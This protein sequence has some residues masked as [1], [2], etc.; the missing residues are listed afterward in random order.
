MQKLVAAAPALAAQPELRG[1]AALRSIDCVAAR[2]WLDRRGAAAFPANVLSGFA[3]LEGAGGTWFHLN[4]LQAWRPGHAGA[5]TH[6]GG[7][8]VHLNGLQATPEC[9][10]GAGAHLRAR[11]GGTWV[12]THEA[13][14][15]AGLLCGPGR[16]RVAHCATSTHTVGHAAVRRRQ[17]VSAIHGCAAAW[18]RPQADTC[19]S[20]SWLSHKR[21]LLT[22]RCAEAGSRYW[23]WH[24]AGC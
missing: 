18:G 15:R 8:W 12:H 9:P 11:V 5:R 13:R 21:R 17:A 10:E 19:L 22:A 6:W 20:H 14:G 3:S 1:T 4:D 24:K 7:A 23:Q 2:L 16:A